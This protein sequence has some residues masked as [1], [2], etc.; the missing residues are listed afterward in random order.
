MMQQLETGEIDLCIASPMYDKPGLGWAEL[1]TEELFLAVPL[2][3]RLAERHSIKLIE[4][5]NE[6]F[7]SLKPGYGLRNIADALCH[8]AGFEPKVAFEGEEVTTARG[9]V[10]AGLGVALVPA[11]A[12]Q[13][14]ADPLPVRLRI[15]E[16]ICQRT[17]A[18][19]WVEGRYLSAAAQLFREF[20][21][22]H[23]AQLEIEK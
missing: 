18:L 6:Y 16:P 9:L 7:I 19:A 10:A 3:H 11:M 12:W 4:A 8:E 2:G 14:V 20:V 13:G 22:A 17:I 5:S 1:M 15:E 23:F 21:V